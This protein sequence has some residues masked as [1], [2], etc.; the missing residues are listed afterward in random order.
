MTVRQRGGDL[1]PV[2]G[3]LA[4]PVDRVVSLKER[5]NLVAEASRVLLPFCSTRTRSASSPRMT[6]RLAAGPK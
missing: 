1:V 4:E 5:S 2:H 6:G 3:G